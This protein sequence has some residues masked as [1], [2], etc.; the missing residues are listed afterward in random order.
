MVGDCTTG[1]R[2]KALQRRL[3][4]LGEDELYAQAEALRDLGIPIGEVKVSPM[5]RC[6]KHGGCFCYVLIFD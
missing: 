4:P 5:E 6:V 3:Q 2:A 1:G